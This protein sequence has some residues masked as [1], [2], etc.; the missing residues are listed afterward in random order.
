MPSAIA[1]PRS[2]AR[3]VSRAQLAK[4][5]PA[6][7]AGCTDRTTCNARAV[8]P[9]RWLAVELTG[10]AAVA[11]AVAEGEPS[12]ASVPLLMRIVNVNVVGD[13]YGLEPGGRLYADGRI[14]LRGTGERIGAAGFTCTVVRVTDR[15]EGSCTARLH[16]PLGQVIGTWPLERSRDSRTR[17]VT[18]GSG[19]YRG[20][21]GRLAL[22][23]TRE[24]GDTPFT[25]ELMR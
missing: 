19:L 3:P 13:R 22:G 16:L 11:A 17:P 18:G 24:N 7:L 1:C 4:R 21:R 5:P 23:P 10:G 14:L 8:T 12:A 6:R 2:G 20:A 9:A 25:V 15:I